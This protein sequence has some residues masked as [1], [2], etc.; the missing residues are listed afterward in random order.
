MDALLALE[1]QMCPKC[2]G[3][4]GLEP[5]FDEG[6][7]GFIQCMKPCPAACDRGRTP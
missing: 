2:G 6:G 7:E 5:L 4:G 3:W 1:V